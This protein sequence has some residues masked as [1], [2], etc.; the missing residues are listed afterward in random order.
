MAISSPGIGSGLDVNSI[1]TQLMTV[2]QQ[3]LATLVKKESSYQAKVSALGTVK[4]ALSTFQASLQSLS[5]TSKFAAS[6]VTAADSTLLTATGSTSAVNG[7]YSLEVT[8]LATAQKLV[9]TGQSSLT[10]SFSTGTISFDFG[11]IDFD[12]NNG[13]SF[14]SSTG[15]YT[16][17]TFTGN[18]SATKTVVIDSGNNTL[19]GI[20]DA[21]N[22][23]D[24]GVTATIVNDGS[25]TPYRLVLT[26]KSTGKASSM[27]IS[28]DTPG[29]LQDLLG[30]DPASNSGQALKETAT[31]QNAEMII[32]GIPASKSSNT[33][34]DLVPGVTLNLLKTNAGSPTTVTVDRDATGIT[35]MVSQ[36]VTSYNALSNKM[37]DLTAYDATTKKAGV[38]NGD[39]TVRTIQTQ[40]SEILNAPITS[41]SNAYTRLAEI[42]VTKQRDG[43][44]SVDTAKL[45]T[46]ITTNLSSV[47]GIFAAVGTPDDSQVTFAG[48]TGK[49]AAGSYAVDITTMPSQGSLTG[50]AATPSS[51]TIDGDNNTLDIQ[52][53]SSTA[54]ITL[55]SGTYNSVADLAAEV[56]SKINAAFTAKGATVSFDTSGG[57]IKLVSSRYGAASNIKVTGGTG[58]VNLFGALPVAA[59]GT[60]VAGTINGVAA[61][62]VG[63]TLTGAASDPSEGLKLRIIGGTTGAR[64]TVEYATGYAFKLNQ[65]TTSLL[66]EDGAVTNRADGLNTALKNLAS[67]KSRLTDRLTIIEKRYRD[68]FTALDNLMSSMT[69]TSS[70]LTQQL[71]LLSKNS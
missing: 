63:Q 7:T 67:Q 37:K 32:D 15:K 4:S 56:Q 52:L 46:A 22:K 20:R 25:S 60:D 40:L 12:P 64:G 55:N 51:L 41:G 66:S 44:L 33:I 30:H 49:T 1:V 59:A 27:K 14:S 38:L 21:I 34:S 45:Q 48:S 10:S 29:T 53:D 47:T 50:V 71:S 58:A 57:V 23:A 35:A 54:S 6:R 3:P 68:Q 24:V 13:G 61:V 69:K 26:D 36:F 2:E 39:S 31:A 28:V 43:T 70:F 11:T 8:K 62:G 65:L 17:A 42:G 5:D 16:G 9:A 18:G 19:A